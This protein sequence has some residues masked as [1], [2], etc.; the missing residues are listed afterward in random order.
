MQHKCR[1]HARRPHHRVTTAAV[2]MKRSSHSRTAVGQSGGGAWRTV[3]LPPATSA[4]QLSG[5]ACCS[6]R[7]ITLQQWGAAQHQLQRVLLRLPLVQP[8]FLLGASAQQRL[9]A[10]LT[11]G[12]SSSSSNSSQH[13]HHQ[14]SVSSVAAASVRSACQMSMLTW[15]MQMLVAASLHPLHGVCTPTGQ[16]SDMRRMHQQADCAAWQRQ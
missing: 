1:L 5:R 11:R 8:A 14:V 12:G 7:R 6:A 13:M 10:A 16:Q 15:H 2:S 9:Q 3:W 4:A